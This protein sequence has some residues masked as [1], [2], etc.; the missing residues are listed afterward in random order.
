VPPLREE[1]RTQESAVAE[2]NLALGGQLVVHRESL[3]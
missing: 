1:V 3:A 2:R